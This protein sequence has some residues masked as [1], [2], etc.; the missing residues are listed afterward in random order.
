MC[1]FYDKEYEECSDKKIYQGRQYFAIQDSF[2]RK[3]LDMF[4]SEFGQNRLQ[5]QRSDEIFD[6]SLDERS[7]FS[8]N[9]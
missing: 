4:H 1:I 9:Q 8:R 5:D 6:Q 3:I 7:N 2:I